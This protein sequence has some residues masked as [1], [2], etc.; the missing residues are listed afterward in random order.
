[1]VAGIENTTETKFYSHGINIF[2][3]TNRF[4]YI[5]VPIPE[6]LKVDQAKT[7]NNKRGFW[8]KV[9]REDIQL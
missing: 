2:T 1:M 8:K 9:C 5:V 7:K 3:W 4:D 6:M